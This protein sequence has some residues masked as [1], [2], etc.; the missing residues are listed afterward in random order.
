MKFKI[1]W[2]GVFV[3]TN[4]HDGRM[5]CVSEALPPQAWQAK[6][7]TCINL[8]NAEPTFTMEKFEDAMGAR[9]L[10]QCVRRASHWE[11]ST[12][13]ANNSLQVCR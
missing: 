5:R 1:G 3:L 6:L 9:A 13:G 11:C 10:L 2:S 8:H 12:L 4:A 7:Y